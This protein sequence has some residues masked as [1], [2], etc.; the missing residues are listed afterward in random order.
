[1]DGRREGRRG[2]G[3]GGEEGEEEEVRSR[4]MRKI[5]GREKDVKRNGGG[6]KTNED[7]RKK[8]IECSEREKN[9]I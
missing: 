8:C 4:G 6:I 9:I 3:G 5:G 1:M 7:D 2:R